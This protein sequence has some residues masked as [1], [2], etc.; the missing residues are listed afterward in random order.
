MLHDFQ[1]GHASQATLRIVLSARLVSPTHVS[2]GVPTPTPD[3][4]HPCVC[5]DMFVTRRSAA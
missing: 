3:L 1:P 4:Q 5:S 2:T